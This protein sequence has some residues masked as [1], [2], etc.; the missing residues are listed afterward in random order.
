[1]KGHGPQQEHPI[2]DAT[3]SSYQLLIGNPKFGIS[4]TS[5][6]CNSVEE[7]TKLRKVPYLLNNQKVQWALAPRVG[8]CFVLRYWKLN[9]GHSYHWA[10]FPVFFSLIQSLLRAKDYKN[11]IPLACLH[12][13]LSDPQTLRGSMGKKSHQLVEYVS[14]TLPLLDSFPGLPVV[15]IQPISLLSHFSVSIYQS[16]CL[17]VGPILTSLLPIGFGGVPKRKQKQ[18]IL[19]FKSTYSPDDNYT[20]VGTFIF[21]ESPNTHVPTP[22]CI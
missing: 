4:Q 13:N 21:S 14:H 18:K 15:V 1:M 17:T 12:M 16:A 7:L 19:I 5:D 8:F 2:S 10:T 20:F 22:F 11:N 9:P 6:V 3:H